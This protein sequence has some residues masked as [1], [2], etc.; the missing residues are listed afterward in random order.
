MNN[1]LVNE[2]SNNFEKNKEK[3]NSSFDNDNNEENS[4]VSPNI[5]LINGME[6]NISNNSLKPNLFNGSYTSKTA[7]KVPLFNKMNAFPNLER[8][9]KIEYNNISVYTIPTKKSS[10]PLP[11]PDFLNKQ[12]KDSQ[13][14]LKNYSINTYINNTFHNNIDNSIVTN[15]NNVLLIDNNKSNHADRLDP[16]NA[17][18]INR[19]KD[20]Y[21]DFLQKQNED[22]N[23]LNFS[24]DSNNKQLLKK[25]SNLIK[26]NIS[27]NKILNEKSN[28]LNKIVQENLNIKSQL[29]LLIANKNKNEQKMQYYE[30]QL[31]YYKCNND[32]YK[33]IVD[34]LKEQN[35]KLNINMNQIRDNNEEDKKDFEERYKN[36][37]EN[38]KKEKNEELDE[39]KKKYEEKI[40]ELNEEIKHLKFQNKELNKELES[41]DNVIKIMYK[42]NQK[43]ITQNK[44]NQVKFEQSTKRIQD[45]NKMIQTKETMINSLK[46][47]DT[48]SD[49]LFLSKSNSCSYMKL[50]GSDFISDNLTKLLNDNEEN[51]VKI[52]YLSD[53]IK[54]MHEIDK[55]CDELI[56]RNS[57]CTYRIRSVGNSRERRYD[58]QS[59]YESKNSKK[60]IL[61][62]YGMEN[63]EINF[64]NK[65][66]NLEL[67]QNN[68][69]SPSV[70]ENNNNANNDSKIINLSQNSSIKEI[71]T[72]KN[73]NFFRNNSFNRKNINYSMNT[74]YRIDSYKCDK[75]DSEEK[76]IKNMKNNNLKII[77]IGKIKKSPEVEVSNI[78]YKGR[79][80]FKA[81]QY[82]KKS[83]DKQVD[84]T[85]KS[86]SIPYIKVFEEE[87][88]DIKKHKNF[89]HISYKHNFFNK[90]RSNDQIII[91]N[92]SHPIENK[93]NK[94][95]S[96]NIYYYL[97]GIDRNNYLHIFDISSLRWITSKKI[98]EINC[99]K[100]AESFR[101]DYQYEGTLLYNMLTGVYILT[102]DKT[103]TLYF[104][105]SHSQSIS[106]ICKFNY[107]HNNGSIKYDEKNKYLYILGGKNTTYCE[108]YSLEDKKVYQ[109]PNLIKDRA[110]ASFVISEGKL[111]G[112]FGFCYSE[113]N[114]VNNIEFL[115]LEKRDKWQELK[116]IQF[117]KENILFNVESVATMYYKND[118][119]KILIYCG[120]EGEDEE[121]ITEY[122]LIYNALNNTMDKIDKWKVNQYKNMGQIWKEYNLTENDPKGFHFAKNSNF[123]LLD[124]N[125]KINGYNE[126]GKIDI[127]IDYKNNVH[128]I[129]QDKEKIDIYRGEI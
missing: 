121:F 74:E 13:L 69:Y 125:Y 99:D 57:N 32:N 85:D 46:T 118:K 3:L 91:I 111:F 27:L 65:K 113:D 33:K 6:T 93:E 18:K 50:E 128:L 64:V 63:Y 61:K 77:E 112:F 81:S 117:L 106:K 21:I 115:D 127:M 60:S 62:K 55:K 114:Y 30:E 124:E 70:V 79:N 82:K 36:K 5:S 42:D 2:N 24:L 25:C 34:E 101:K 83:S 54:T 45:L 17:I 84:N 105:N 47:K 92:Q 78:I 23:K 4:K 43:L 122:Y 120:I 1:F 72:D 102:G 28:R 108:Y 29:D 51:K 58:N 14:L 67:N 68:R 126:T 95:I 48:E 44:L 7:E 12:E 129:S 109:L 49:K 76:A 16:K 80:F 56:E 37:I 22:H 26:D 40:K 11:A 97:Y 31:E 110:N 104:Y 38:I 35:Q 19:I 94:E 41:K 88:D 53:K 52:E 71:N 73:D 96:N 107:G 116:N 8:N 39:L 9:N 66:L 10:S 123:I 100:N 75:K 90:R 86:V 89:T 103:D 59:Y 119:S 15:N 87:K 98:F 20:T